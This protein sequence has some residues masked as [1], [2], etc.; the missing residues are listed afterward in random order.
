MSDGFKKIW[1]EIKRLYLHE[2]QPFPESVCLVEINENEGSEEVNRKL[3][4][5]FHIDD[6]DLVLK[7][8]NHRKSLI[9]INI[10]P[11][12][13]T[14]ESV[15]QKETVSI[16]KKYMEL[17]NRIQKLEASLPELDKKRHNRIIVEVESLEQKLDFLSKR[18]NETDQVKW[19]GMFKKN[20]LW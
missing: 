7:L 15:A 19:K 14:I 3:R 9:P 16:K 12:R 2:N 20:P 18:L 13:R 6:L 5:T 10:T 8:R 11:K 17:V 4:E 1:I